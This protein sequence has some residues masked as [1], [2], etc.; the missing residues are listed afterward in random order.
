VVLERR[1]I[2][3]YNNLRSTS[4]PCLSRMKRNEKG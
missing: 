1:L 3:F 4:S 2:V